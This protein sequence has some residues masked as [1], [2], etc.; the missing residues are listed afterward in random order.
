LKI[1]ITGPVCLK[2]LS[3]SDSLELPEAH[4]FPPLSFFVMELLSRGHRIDVVTSGKVNKMWSHRSGRLSITVVPRRARG[5]GSDFH[6]EERRH[7]VN[8]L[9][10]SSSDIVHA[11][12]TYEY[13]MAAQASGKHCLVTA[14]DAPFAILRYMR[15]VPYWT[16]RALMSLPVL[17]RLTS[18][19]VIS[20]Y[21]ETYFRRYHFYRNPIHV[22]PEFLSGTARNYHREREIDPKSPV[23]VSVNVGWG[24]RKNVASLVL[25]FSMLHRKIPRARLILYGPGYG[26]GEAAEQF[27][28]SMSI[29]SGITF[30]GARPG[31]LLLSELAESADVLV[32]P[33]REESFCVSIADAMAMGIP[34][35][36][37]KTSGAV[38]WL[39]DGGTCGCLVDVNNREEIAAAMENLVNNADSATLYRRNAL[40]RIDR[41]FSLANTADQYEKIYAR[42]INSK[43]N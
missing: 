13:A 12:W 42:I 33:S 16:A 40:S 32:H 22:I 15:P 30:A 37:G 19:C 43:T 8:A 7:L 9:K 6:R 25:A 36:A 14:H 38:P 21:L 39:L 28:K 23:F 31:L 27:A 11:H 26:P 3:L 10:L 29:E 18:L 17:W 35:I 2:T 41:D 20:P 1:A 24:K 4:S 5:C 34:V